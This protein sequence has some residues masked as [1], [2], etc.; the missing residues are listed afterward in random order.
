MKK[1]KAKTPMEILTAGHSKFMKG[2]QANANGKRLF[3]K[4]LKKAVKQ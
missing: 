4:A 3:G 2:K 1:K